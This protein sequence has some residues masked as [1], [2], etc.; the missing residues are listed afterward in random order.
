[1]RWYE[2]FFDE[3]YQKAYH[4]LD[5]ER[6][7]QEVDLIQKLLELDLN[8]KILDIPCGS[9]RHAIELTRRGFNVVGMEYHPAQIEAAK[10]SMKD[11]G[12]K[13]ELI[14]ADMRDIPHTEK[15]DRL[16]NFFTSFGFFSD[17]ENEKTLQQFY[18]ALKPGGLILLDTINRDS[19]IRKFQAHI[20]HRFNNGNIWLQENRFIPSTSRMQ[21]RHTLIEADGNTLERDVDL[22][23]Y[24]PHE[25][26]DMFVRNKFH[27]Q[28]IYNEEGKPFKAFSKRIVVVAKKEG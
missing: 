5:R 27:I 6:T 20:V 9:G 14:Q 28:G 23:L 15:Y 17:E 4:Y 13:F 22:R 12:V 19:V 3:F 26:V 10:E 11:R 1:M 7:A 2:S 16:Y 18:K 21:T 24:S 8:H 25:L